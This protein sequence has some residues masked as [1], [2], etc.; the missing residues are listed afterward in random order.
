MPKVERN[1][2]QVVTKVVT[3]EVVKKKKQKSKAKR[4]AQGL[5]NM[6]KN[7]GRSDSQRCAF[8]LLNADSAADAND[9]IDAPVSD[10]SPVHLFVTETGF[11]V[12]AANQADSAKSHIWVK[13][14][15]CPQGHLN[16]ATA[17]DNSGTPSTI[18][19]VNVEGY[20]SLTSVYDD[21]RCCAIM[22]T[23]KDSS[24]EEKLN[25]TIKVLNVNPSSTAIT[26]AVIDDFPG[27]EYPPN[28]LHYARIPWVPARPEVDHAFM[29]PT[30]TINNE[31]TSV[32]VYGTFA[33]IATGQMS[34]RVRVFAVWAG[35]V[36]PTADFI[37]APKI[38]SIDTALFEATLM[39]EFARSPLYGQARIMAK[40]DGGIS[41][42]VQ[43]AQSA[44]AGGKKLF[45][46][47][48]SLSDRISGGIDMVRSL[49]SIGSTIAG[50]FSMEDRVVARLAGMSDVELLYAQRL[51]LPGRNPRGLSCPQSVDIDELYDRRRFMRRESS[52]RTPLVFS[53]TRLFE[54]FEPADDIMA[55]DWCYEVEKLKR[56][57]R[58]VSDRSTALLPLTA[59]PSPVHSVRPN[60][61]P[62]SLGTLRREG[63]I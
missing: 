8:Q 51:L 24:V 46:A 26:E 56:D 59:P 25:G 5:L 13:A 12:N 54:A 62:A 15:P 48:S 47:D 27:F 39:A 40:D 52:L 38:F 30:A 23:V 18:T 60:A 2:K 14:S 29:S 57:K 44:F 9:L 41:G 4:Q 45:G 21:L 58:P 31:S 35:R 42:M 3:K 50:F 16:Y 36:L 28:K 11:T 17:F 32:Q 1:K 55:R 19:G 6:I 61:I 22:V 37:A 53:H 7:V 10:T 43:D 20:A 34:A 63:R 49:G 33:P